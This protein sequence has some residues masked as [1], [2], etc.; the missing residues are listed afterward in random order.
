MDDLIFNGTVHR[1]ALNFAEVSLTFDRA[2][3]HLPID[4]QEI[5]VTRRMYR[6][7]EGEYYLNKTLCRLK[8]IAELFWDTGIGREA[9][10]LIGQGRVEKLI[11]AKPEE[12]RE[13]FEE[14]AEIH[15]YKQRKKETMI[16]LAEMNKNLLR[17][18]DILTELK[19]QSLPLCEAAAITSKYRAFTSELQEIEKTILFKKWWKNNS[20]L[21]KIEEKLKKNS[22]V[23]QEKETIL[24]RL[25]NRTST[26]KHEE[27]L[28]IAETNKIKELFQKQ[29][30][31]LEKISSQL[32]LI[33]EQRRHF[34]EKISTK[35]ESC[36]EVQARILG[37]EESCRKNESSLKNIF[38]EQKLLG[39]KATK[40]KESRETLQKKSNLA[41]LDKLKQQIAEKNMQKAALEQLLKSSKLRYKELCGRIEES[42]EREKAKKSELDSLQKKEKKALAL[43]QKLEWDSLDLTK[44]QELL[45]QRQKDLYRKQETRKNELQGLEKDLQKNKS[46]LK[47]LKE[48]EDELSFYARGVRAVMNNYIKNPSDK[49]IFGPVANLIS[50]PQLFEKAL[51]VALGARIQF[52]VVSDDGSARKAIEFLKEKKAGRATFLPLTLLKPSFGKKISASDKKEI[53]GIA[54]QLVETQTKFKKVVENLLGGVL[55][56]KN[57]E[58][59]LKLARNNKA[60]WRIVT[61]DGEMITPGGAISGGYQ[62]EERSGFLQRKRELK[63][64]ETKIVEIQKI[65]GQ[66]SMELEKINKNIS[67]LLKNFA[68]LDLESKKIEK[69]RNGIQ[70]NLARIEVEKSRIQKEITHLSLEKTELLS[71]RHE[72][73]EQIAGAEKSHKLLAKSLEKLNSELENLSIQVEVDEKHYQSLEEKLV[74]IRIKFSALQE[75]ESSLQGIFHKQTQEK[76]RLK[77]IYTRHAEEKKHIQEELNK[78][79]ATAE[80]MTKTLEEGKKEIQDLKNTLDTIGNDLDHY[81]QATEKLHVETEKELKALQRAE[82]QQQ[83]TNIELIKRQEAEKYL[84]ESLLE[85]F[86]FD[87]GETSI[88]LQAAKP[89]DVLLEEKELLENKIQ[90][91]GEV[92]LGA[93][94]EYERLQNRITFL[95]KQRCDLQSGEKGIRKVLEELDE[96]MEGKFLQALEAIKKNFKD[97]FAQLFG[98]GQAFLKPTDPE[99]ILES[100]IEIIAQPPGKKL[101]SISLLSSGEKALT[102]IALLFAVL[103]YKPVPFCVLDEIDSSLDESNLS[104]YVHFLKKYAAATQFVVITHRRKTMEEAD[105]LYGITMEEQGISK[106]VSLD[107]NEKAG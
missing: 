50:V 86:G 99:N 52:I 44:E 57:L 51:E 88:D 85:K 103:Q 14:A 74:E 101:Q 90:L 40:L 77:E 46:R 21:Q 104:K 27:K 2:D 73:S 13:L 92:D 95:E 80:S 32:N 34:L 43:L 106:V 83:N 60:G 26:V 59:A 35:D 45:Q 4:Y 89:E 5:I 48:S 24:K 55:I 102:A 62:P 25:K 66:K 87:P 23:I 41:A 70:T 8:D 53:F 93:I 37:L 7:G 17:V 64:L 16:R 31:K 6:S 72:L 19:N 3:K 12:N 36:K 98:G 63:N 56:A 28:K 68:G 1:K 71:K 105:F 18:E 54:S 78:L 94:D 84:K 107:L 47:F 75:K 67:E 29:R 9:Y 49:G 76:E 82:R 65:S 30:E 22:I 10:S 61:P 38:Q 100:G 91:L 33:R 20:R 69:E 96:H 15:K 11:N 42:E 97:I 58:A 81:K 79:K 39:G